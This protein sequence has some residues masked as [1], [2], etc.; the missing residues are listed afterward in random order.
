MARMGPGA[1]GAGLGPLGGWP[2]RHGA[3]CHPFL[4]MFVVGQAVMSHHGRPLSVDVRS[5]RQ[6]TSSAAIMEQDPEFLGK[7][8][9]KHHFK[10]KRL[11][12]R[13]RED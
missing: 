11:C 9:F 7:L 1:A 12:L 13:N 6:V 2:V 3:Q 4:R 5:L 8:H 10:I